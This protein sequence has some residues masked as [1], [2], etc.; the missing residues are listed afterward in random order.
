MLATLVGQLNIIDSIILSVQ[1]H[2]FMCRRPRYQ[3]PNS[4]K[5]LILYIG[6]R[7][8]ADVGDIGYKSE[9]RFPMVSLEFSLDINL[10][11]SLVPWGRLR[12]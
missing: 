11:A 3:S 10:P 5:Y 6:A 2:L 1:G 8:S 9:G 4:F 7:V 12:L